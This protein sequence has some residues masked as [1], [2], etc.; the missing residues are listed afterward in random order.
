MKNS[1]IKVLVMLVSVILISM[2]PGTVTA[3]RPENGKGMGPGPGPGKGECMAIPDLTEEQQTAIEQLRIKHF[4]KAELIRAE[5]GEK[6]ARLVTLRVAE[7][8]DVKAI[9]NTIDDISKLRGDLMKMREA[10]QR[11]IKVL[12]NDTQKAYFDARK[13]K[14]RKGN[15]YGHRGRHDGDG[16]GRGYGPGNRGEC[17]YAK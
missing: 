12:L 4:R 3:Q 7:K 11:E 16:P 5:I 15:G 17:P 1:G 13:G 10:H 14:G 6:E 8:E 9:D 2:V